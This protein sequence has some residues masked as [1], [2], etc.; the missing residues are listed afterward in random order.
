M[1]DQTE[2]RAVFTEFLATALYVFICCG[3]VT[4][5]GNVTFDE[6]NS[7]RLV[8]IALTQGLA[9]TVLLYLTQI[10]TRYGVGYMNP[11]VTLAI[12]L[13]NASHGR[14]QWGSEKNGKDISRVIFFL[15]AQFAGGLFGAALVVATIPNAAT[16]VTKIGAPQLN[17]GSTV[18]SGFVFEVFGTFFLTWVILTNTC[19]TRSVIAKNVSAPMAIGLAMCALQIFAYPFTGASFNP[20]RAFSPVVVAWNF[21]ANL[22]IYMIAPVIGALFGAII[23]ILAFTNDP[24]R[25]GF[26]YNAP[27]SM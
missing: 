5:T 2:W 13:T 6:L 15:I 20:V 9:Y 10:T 8:V 4:S 19:R 16:G 7:P 22:V 25:F 23:Y 17:Y 14:Y 1:P 11:A 27:K 26:D 21:E 12:G 3:I 24:L 18:A